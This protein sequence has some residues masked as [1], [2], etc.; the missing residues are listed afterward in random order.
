MIL[1]QI[2]AGGDRN[3]AYLIGDED[4]GDAAV[5]DPANGGEEILRLAAEKGLS[6]RYVINTHGHYDHT[7]DNSLVAGRSGAVVAGYGVSEPGIDVRDGDVLMLGS[8]ELRVIHTPGHTGDSICILAGG[9]ALITGDTLFVGK[10]GGT[11]FGED[12]RQEYDSL[13]TKL[14]TLPEDVVV[15]PGHDYGVRPVSTIGDEKRTNPF[16]LRD[17]FDSFVDL[18]RNWQAYKREHGIS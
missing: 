15:Y 12:A 7:G 11:G 4:S 3:F 9:Q 16:M 13:H 17:G 10:V 1:E 5:V 6:L 18:K 8:L 2:R 14:M